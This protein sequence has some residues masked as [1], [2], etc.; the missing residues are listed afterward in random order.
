LNNII[1]IGFKS[2]G[3]TTYGQKLAQEIGFHF[4]DTDVLISNNCR[5]LYETDPFAF[6]RLEKQVIA[7]LL[8]FHSCVIAT[9]GGTILDSDNIAIL[10]RLG[11]IIY[12]KV[13]KEI[14]KNR[15]LGGELPAFLDCHDPEGSF[16]KMY[17]ER[18]SL[19]ENIA[20]EIYE[21]ISLF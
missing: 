11:K 19:Y 5:D 20:D 6:R 2:C 4:I 21:P 9:G 14:I 1:L 18:A 16:E 10:K 3:K 17:S 15:L 8:E 13:E 7:A 12:L